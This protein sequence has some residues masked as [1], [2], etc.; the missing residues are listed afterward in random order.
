MFDRWR[1]VYTWADINEKLH[2]WTF[3]FHKVVWQQ[4]WSEVTA[5]VCAS[6]AVYYWMRE[7]KSYCNRSKFAKIIITM[8]FR[9]GRHGV[10]RQSIDITLVQI[11]RTNRH[12][13]EIM[14]ANLVYRHATPKTRTNFR[15]PSIYYGTPTQIL[16]SWPIQ[17][18]RSL[19]WL[20]F[21]CHVR[22][23]VTSNSPATAVHYLVY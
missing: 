23:T 18:S 13:L 2:S 21:Y 8:T 7:W 12:V 4:I 22:T 17:R 5:L 3:N 11:N 15:E 1:C 16:G 14:P 10:V 19:F 6:S 9:G 20:D